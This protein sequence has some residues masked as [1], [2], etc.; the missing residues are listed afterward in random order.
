[1]DW[2]IQEVARLAGTTSR[3]LRHYGD[4]GLLEPSRIGA[5]GYRYYDERALARLQ[6]IL[7]LRDLGLGIPAIAEVLRGQRDDAEA[8]AV[9]LSWLRQEKSRLDLQIASVETTINKMEGG[10]QLMAEEMLNGFD[11]TQYREEVEQRWG[12]QAYADSNAWWSSLSKSGQA[13]WMQQQKQLAADWQAAAARGLDPRGDEAQALAQRHADWLAGIPGTP[14]V[15]RE[16]LTGLGEMYVADE[17]FGANY[18]GTEGAS[19]VRDALVAYAE[20]HL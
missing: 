12:K 9:H 20:E 4:V 7:M 14:P 18:G 11:N 10:E 5:N 15:S 8:L 19:F 3:T 1:M 6:R 2:S 16:Y 17:R 13:E